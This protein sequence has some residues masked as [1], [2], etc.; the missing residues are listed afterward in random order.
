M[1]VVR[2]LEQHLVSLL[3]RVGHLENAGGE[4]LA[5]AKRRRREEEL[6]LDC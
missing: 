1:S 3:D 5:G 2:S 6:E 4:G